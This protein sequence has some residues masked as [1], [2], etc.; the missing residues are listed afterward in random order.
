MKRSEVADYLK[1]AMV[2]RTD[3]LANRHLL[4]CIVMML[5][6]IAESRDLFD[7]EYKED[8]E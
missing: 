1:L 3:A 4:M 2:A 5:Y 7:D 6:A 8:E